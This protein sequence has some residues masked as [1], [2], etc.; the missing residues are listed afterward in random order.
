MG[1]SEGYISSLL[2]GRVI[3]SLGPVFSHEPQAMDA[4]SPASLLVVKNKYRSRYS[5]TELP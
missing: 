1:C 2:P 5:S 4:G 3:S